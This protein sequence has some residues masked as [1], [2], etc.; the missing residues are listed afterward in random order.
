MLETI[1]NTPALLFVIA[2][3][4]AL[5]IAGIVYLMVKSTWQ[6]KYVELEG[7][8]EQSQRDAVNLREELNT[9][10]TNLENARKANLAL[11]EEKKSLHNKVNALEKEIEEEIQD[12]NEQ[13]SKLEVRLEKMEQELSIEKLKNIPQ[14][15]SERKK[16]ATKSN[17]P[18]L[19][20]TNEVTE[21]PIETLKDKFTGFLKRITSSSEKPESP[22]SDAEIIEEDDK[23]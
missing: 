6:K 3:L 18:E 22:I 17:T 2:I 9:E 7:F 16:E 1:N 21:K 15:L 8:Y 20:N 14:N 23:I 12:K 5:I 11:E 10:K 19:T 4:P 13:L